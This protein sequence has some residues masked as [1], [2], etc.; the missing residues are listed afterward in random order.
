MN[1]FQEKLSENVRV[2][3]LYDDSYNTFTSQR[4]QT[5]CYMD[6]L[7]SSMTQPIEIVC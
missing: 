7:F 4:G 3:P 2:A 6:Q 1:A 5:T